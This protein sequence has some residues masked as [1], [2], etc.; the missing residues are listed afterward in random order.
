MDEIL[1]NLGLEL[2]DVGSDQDTWGDILNENLRILDNAVTYDAITKTL[3]AVDVTL[4][5]AEAAHGVI[6]L[7][8]TLTANVNLIV[9][10]SPVRLYLVNNGTTGA[11]TVTVK[12]PLGTGITVLQGANSLV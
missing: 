11:F 5:T 12:T 9:P 8:G 6:N 4:T 2:P 7:D 1:P 3:G 10:V